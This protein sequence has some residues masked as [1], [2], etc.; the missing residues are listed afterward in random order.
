MAL[1]SIAPV[2]DEGRSIRPYPDVDT[3]KPRVLRDEDIRFMAAEKSAPIALKPFHVGSQPMH[4]HRVE[5]VAIILRPLLA[6]VDHHPDMS[7]SST[8]SI[9]G[10]VP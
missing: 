7:V 4:V 3:S 6:L 1:T 9:R 10:T 8:E 2:D 5:L